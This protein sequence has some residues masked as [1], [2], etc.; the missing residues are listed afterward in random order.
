MLG[1]KIKLSK[2]KRTE[3]I[4]SA[5][6]PQWNEIRSNKDIWAIKPHT[7]NQPMVKEELLS[8]I[9]KYFEVNENEDTI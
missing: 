4:K 1:Y 2:F 9:R 6:Q 8:E 5:W 3:I 7:T